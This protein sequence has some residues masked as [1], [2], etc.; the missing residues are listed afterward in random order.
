V[1]KTLLVT[2]AIV[3]FAAA[4]RPAVV[5]TP[6]AKSPETASNPAAP[7]TDADYKKKL[8]PEQYKILRCGG[9]ERPGSGAY[10]E[11]WDKGVYKCAACG[12]ELF[13]SEMKYKSCDWP[14]FFS[15]IGDNVAFDRET[16][17]ATCAKCDS[18]L[19]HIFNDGPKPTGK[20]Y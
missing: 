7:M 16:L 14:S 3:A 17:E 15:H 12:N 6:M 13:T 11:F 19:G 10:L 5:E 1:N 4:C 20:R 9:T 8:T 2:A 18:H